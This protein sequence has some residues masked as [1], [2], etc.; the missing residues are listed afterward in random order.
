MAD[1]TGL[2]HLRRGDIRQRDD[3][4]LAD[5]A[6]LDVVAILAVDVRLGC[7]EGSVGELDDGQ[8]RFA[9]GLPV[10]VKRVHPGELHLDAGDVA[11]EHVMQHV[12]VVDERVVDDV[13]GAVVARGCLRV[14]VTHAGHQQGAD[15]S[16]AD[17]GLHRVVAGVEAPVETDLN[18]FAALG[19]LGFDDLPAVGAVDGH[20]LFGERRLADRDS[21]QQRVE[22]HVVAAGDD[23]GVD[24]RIVDQCIGRIVDR[25]VEAVVFDGLFRVAEHGVVYADDLRVAAFVRDPTHVVAAHGAASDETD[26]DHG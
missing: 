1:L 10:R 26:I 18:G 9:Q 20:R 12:E 3:A 4:G 17:E 15:L 8:L 2:A 7:G 6:A 16:V 23:D 14:V 22:M 19:H 5:Q 24:V 21:V 11:V 13:V 25:R